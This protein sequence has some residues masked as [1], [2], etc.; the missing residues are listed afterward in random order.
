LGMCE[1]GEDVPKINDVAYLVQMIGSKDY[2]RA[3][4]SVEEMV[5][6]RTP[7]RSRERS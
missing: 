4:A 3:R 1:R 2:T 6:Q 7:S 5:D